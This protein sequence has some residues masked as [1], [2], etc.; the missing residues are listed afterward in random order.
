MPPKTKENSAKWWTAV[1]A[2]GPG[3]VILGA[4][5]QIGGAFLAFYVVKHG[6]AANADEPVEMYRLGFAQWTTGAALTLAVIFVTLSQIKINTT[7]AYS[8]SLSWSN[9]FS[10]LLHRHP[11]RFVWI[12]FAVGISL[13][14]MEVNV[15]KFLNTVL[16]FYSNVAIAW[17]GAI[18]AD[19]VINKPVGW[20]PPGIEFK[21][22]HLR[23]FNPV[24]FGSMLVASFVSI[25]A[26]FKVF[27]GDTA[28]AY[29]PFIALAIGFGLSPL[30]AYLTKGKYYTARVDQMPDPLWIDDNMSTAMHTCVVCAEAFERPDVAYC[31]FDA[32]TGTICSLCCSVDSDCHDMCK[33]GGASGVVDLTMPKARSGA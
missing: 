10:R 28:K 7:N 17:I 22:A 18:T 27:G 2:A 33:K 21:R 25:L 20:S 3:W 24:G 6:V 15:F 19:L 16:G 11:G 5:K 23:N 1:I 30:L 9:F 14:L 29:S 12:F 13:V 32:H 31:P 26:Y 8:G 4:L